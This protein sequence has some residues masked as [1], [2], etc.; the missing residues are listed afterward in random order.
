[1]E[2]YTLLD[3]MIERKNHYQGRMA[4]NM[5]NKVYFGKRLADLTKKRDKMKQDSEE[6]AQMNVEIAA[7]Q[8]RISTA[9]DNVEQDEMFMASFNEM[10][11]SLK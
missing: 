1:M 5:A 2:E 10:I 3:S 7:A 9:D 8:T 6:R 4:E 11:K